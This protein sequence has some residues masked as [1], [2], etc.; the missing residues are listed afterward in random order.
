MAHVQYQTTVDWDSTLKDVG[1]TDTDTIGSAFAGLVESAVKVTAGA[2]VATADKFIPG[3][4]VQN[5]VTGIGYINSG[6]TAAPTWSVISIGGGGGMII[7]GAVTGGTATQVLFVGVGA[8][9]DQSSDFLWDDAA[10]DFSV[11]DLASSNNGTRFLVTDSAPLISAR[12]DGLYSVTTVL[13]SRFLQVNTTVGSEYVY[14]GDIDTA[15]NGTTLILDDNAQ[16]IQA[17]A[18]TAGVGGEFQVSQTASGVRYTTGPNSWGVVGE[19]TGGGQLTFFGGATD[20]IWPAVDGAGGTQLTTDGAGNLSWSAS[21]SGVNIGDV[22]GGGPTTNAVIFTN[23]ANQLD[24]SGAFTFNE[25]TL[26][27]IAGTAGTALFKVTPATGTISSDCRII[28]V[29]G[30]STIDNTSAGMSYNSGV[31]GW[32]FFADSTAGG[33]AYVYSN[34]NAFTWPNAFGAANSVLKD[35][36]G[37]GTLSFAPAAFTGAALGTHSHDAQYTSAE[38]LTVTA[39][40]GVSSA[41]VNIP[42]GIVEA[43]YV[44]AGGVTGAVTVIPAGQTPATKECTYNQATGVFQFLIADAVTDAVISYVSRAVTLVSAGTPAGTIV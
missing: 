17:Q 9:L 21:S 41:A 34:N 7:G 39:G 12:V 32:G 8:V 3:A 28:G 26:E 13:G 10:K 6:S 14:L 4:I 1:Y 33:R 16:S 20:Y 36:A 44:T 23:G 42:I 27:M 18:K 15:G 37:N 24:Q 43:V 25:I 40:T 5:A 22:V 11:G 2:P 29:G 31:A 19:S 35:V 38:A 30:L